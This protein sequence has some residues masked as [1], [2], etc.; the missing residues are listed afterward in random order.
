MCLSRNVPCKTFYAELMVPK[1][2]AFLITTRIVVIAGLFHFKVTKWRGTTFL[3]FF[4]LTALMREG[5]FGPN[6]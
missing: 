6:T 3:A 4:F 5:F 2:A 1:I